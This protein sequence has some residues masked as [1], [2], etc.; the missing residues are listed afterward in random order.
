MAIRVLAETAVRHPEEITLVPKERGEAVLRVLRAAREHLLISLFRCDD[1]KVIDELANAC[2]RGVRVQVLLT[3]R[4]K[5]W[6][7]KLKELESFLQSLGAEVRRYPLLG[8]KYHAKYIVADDGPALIASLNFT[9]KHFKTT[10]D[11]LFVTH[12][13][14]VILGLK[15]VFE[16]D[17]TAEVVSLP[18]NLTDRLI[19]G[20]NRSRTQIGA[21][22]RQAR[23]SIRIIDHRLTDPAMLAL[24][25]A[26]KAEGVSVEVLG[27]GELE[28][29]ASHGRMIVIDEE[30]ATIGSLALSTPSL[31]FRREV[32]ALLRDPRSVGQLNGFFQGL[33]AARASAESTSF[34]EAAEGEDEEDTDDFPEADAK[35]RE[36]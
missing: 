20:P 2:R 13:P 8:L 25:K 1:F 33:L 19:V 18:E 15:R 36:E 22:L 10:C 35:D 12:D 24:L 4:A 23:R 3:P 9:R 21:L 17:C 14:E 7:K 34:D 31:D 16:T 29:L 11:F 27:R 26:K 28:G 30:V 5:G 32:V 6:K